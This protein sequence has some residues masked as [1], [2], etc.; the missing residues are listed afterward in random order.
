M[1]DPVMKSLEI[2]GIQEFPSILTFFNLKRVK[3]TKGTIGMQ[4]TMWAKDTKGIKGANRAK[5][6]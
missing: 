1:S 6:G 4:G 5:R 2:L 3:E